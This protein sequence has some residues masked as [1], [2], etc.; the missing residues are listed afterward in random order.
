M[1]IVTTK[2][3]TKV[4]P[5]GTKALDKLNLDLNSR[6]SC[7]IGRNGAGK[8]TL[9][10]ILSTQLRPTSGK[11]EIMGYDVVRDR[12]KIRKIICSIPQEVKPVGIASPLEHVAMYLTARGF[13]IKDALKVSRG[14]LTELGLG[15]FMNKPSDELSGGMKR[16]IFVAMAIAS[17]ADLVFLDEPTVGLDPISRLEVWG[18]LRRLRSRVVLT[19]H[20]MEE[21][22]A[23]CEEIAIIEKGKV[24]RSGSLEELM[25]PLKGKVRVE[26]YG[27]MKIGSMNIAYLSKEE[28]KIIL[29]KYNNDRRI[30]IKPVS[31]EDVFI[32][33]GVE[34]EKD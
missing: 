3:L 18:A 4:Y 8:T 32:L 5:N 15:H 7:I 29:D 31:L 24:V 25:E 11:A 2:N 1:G 10:R 28:A 9:I 12:E 17:N 6:I 23:L 14:V 27:E 34:V 20:Y 16:K 22:E 30:S 19:T 21:A 13:S 26:G 33:S